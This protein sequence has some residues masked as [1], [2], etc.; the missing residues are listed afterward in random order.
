[1]DDLSLK[2][3]KLIKNT[4][5]KENLR[6]KGSHLVKKYNWELANIEINNKFLKLIN[7]KIIK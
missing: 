5:L 3:M 6:L 1:M 7:D 2:M 4:E